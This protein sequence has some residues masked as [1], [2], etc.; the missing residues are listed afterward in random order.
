M[1]DWRSGDAGGLGVVT[2][3][4]CVVWTLRLASE[5]GIGE[6]AAEATSRTHHSLIHLPQLLYP[7]RGLAG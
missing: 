3:L 5:T 7:L 2:M 1:S 4:H 6:V